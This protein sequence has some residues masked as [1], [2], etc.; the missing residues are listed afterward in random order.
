MSKKTKT[1]KTFSKIW[2]EIEINRK[3]IYRWS[4]NTKTR[5]TYLK[6]RKTFFHP[7][8]Y[9]AKPGKLLPE[10]HSPEKHL[11]E[12]LLPERLSTHC[13]VVYSTQ[14]TTQSQFDFIFM[15]KNGNPFSMKIKNVWTTPQI[16]TPISSRMKKTI[17]KKLCKK[18]F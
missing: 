6:T 18:L 8:N 4:Q 10:K 2:S 15:P 16:A 14:V 1:R 3:T 11:P 17:Q 5:K 13:P 12:K 7:K 9:I